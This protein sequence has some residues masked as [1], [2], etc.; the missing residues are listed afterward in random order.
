MLPIIIAVFLI[1]YTALI[2]YYFYY[3]LRIKTPFSKKNVTANVSVIVAARNEENHIGRLVK[4]LQ[5]QSFPKQ[6]YEIIIVDDYSTDGTSDVVRSLLNEYTRLI[7]PEVAAQQSSKKRA[8]EAGVK[9]A[10]GALILVT[11]ADC[12]PPSTWVGTIAQFQAQTNAV[13]I[14]APVK[15]TTATSILSIFQSLDFITLQGITAAGVTANALSMCNGANLAYLRSA[16]FEVEGFKGVDQKA[17]GDDMLLMHKIWEKH[18]S[19]VFYLR[20]K[21]AI[22]ETEPMKTWRQFFHQRIRWS[23]KATYYNDKRIMGVLLFV[24]LFNCLFFVLLFLAIVNVSHF[25]LLIYYLVGKTLIEFPFVYSVTRFYNEQK[26]MWWFPF[27]QPLH[28][29]YTV[30]IG[31]ISQFGT[32]EWKGRRTK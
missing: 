27:F 3:W 5:A 17:S 13:F 18:P 10:K 23:S 19:S 30:L 22:V 8:I 14:A 1:I 9:A 4:A 16:F 12:L 26:S 24:Y 6:Q 21:K 28:I 25:D 29:S 11:D 15:F 7:Q 31:L 2:F 32:Y 20:D